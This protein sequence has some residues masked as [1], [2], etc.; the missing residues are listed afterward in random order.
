[1]EEWTTLAAQYDHFRNREFARLMGSLG[2]LLAGPPDVSIHQ[3][4][5]SMTLDEAAP[6]RW[7]CSRTCMRA[8]R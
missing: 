5:S 1:V 4:A 2:D 8:A 3:V 6:S 7:R